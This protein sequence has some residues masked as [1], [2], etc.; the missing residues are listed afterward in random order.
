LATLCKTVAIVDV[1]LSTSIITTM[2]LLTLYRCNRAGDKEV[3]KVGLA[4]FIAANL[5]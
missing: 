5:I 2:L 4:E 3:C 1:A